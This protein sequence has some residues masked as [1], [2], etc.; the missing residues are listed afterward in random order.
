MAPR[1]RASNIAV[2]RDQPT[3]S[4]HQSPPSSIGHVQT[5]ARE[6]IGPPAMNGHRGGS[7]RPKVGQTAEQFRLHEIRVLPAEL[8]WHQIYGPHPTR[9]ECVHPQEADCRCPEVFLR[10]QDVF[11]TLQGLR[12]T[13]DLFLKTRPHFSHVG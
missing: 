11:P 1:H 8:V 5:L 7:A 12:A 13:R 9:Q 6:A 3:G 4:I 10:Q 2:P